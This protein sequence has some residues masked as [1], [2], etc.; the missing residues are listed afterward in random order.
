[1][2]NIKW[3]I[4]L[5]C[6]F[7]ILACKQESASS[8]ETTEAVS[9]TTADAAPRSLANRPI[10]PVIGLVKPI[11]LTG[12]QTELMLEDYFM[13]VSTIE[14]F[15]ASQGLE[16]KRSADGKSLTI[17]VI[18][19]PAFYSVLS[20][21]TQ[22][23]NFDFLLQQSEKRKVTLRLRDKGYKKVQIKGEMN[24]WNPASAEMTLNRGIWEH[25]FEVHPGDYQ[26]LFV[27]DG[28][29][30][31]DPKNPDTAPNGSGGI[32]SLLS[33]PKP[34]TAELPRIYGVRSSANSIT[35]G[36]DRVGRL[37]VFWENQLLAT[38]KKGNEYT[39]LLPEEAQSRSRSFVRAF[40]Q[41]ERGVSN[42]MLLPIEKGALVSD[43]AQLNRTDKEA[44]IMYF[45]LVDRFNNG[46][47][48]NDQPVKDDRVLPQ[49]N[50][51]GGDI[52]GIT[53]KIK[54]GYFQSLNI[55]AIWLSP[56]TQN[57]EGAFQEYPEPRRW[58]TGYHGYWPVSS[59]KVDHRFGTSG[60]L[61]E[62]VEVA[63]Q[64]DINILLD[65]VCNHV[66]Q[67]HPIFQEHPE[68]ATQLDLP[69][70]RRNLRLWDE[71]RLTTWFDT[72]LPSL[73]LSDPEAIEVQS[74]SAMFWLQ[75]YGLDGFRHD[76]TKHVPIE[77]WR[78]LTRKLKE[79]VM[80]PQGRSIYQ[81]GETYG[82][83]ELIA[84]YIS[85][86]LLDSQ[87]DFNLYFDARGIIAQSGTDFSRLANSLQETF[88]Y[89]GHH[90]SM[91]YISG[92]HDIP[93]FI[94]LAG[95][96]LKFDENDREAGFNRS[97]GV[98]DP[99][100][101]KRLQMMHA[102][103]MSIPGVPVI[104]YGD[105]IGIPGAGD[106][107]NRRMMRFSGWSENEANTKEVVAQLTR[108]RKER[109]SLTY[110]ETEVLLAEKDLLVLLRSYF[111][112]LTIIVFNKSEQ[113][114]SLRFTLPDRFSDIALSTSFGHTVKQ[115]GRQ[116]SVDLPEVGF[117]MLISK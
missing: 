86:G 23:G 106:P 19:D 1:M 94:S 115:E 28:E 93:R 55:N 54:D 42:D 11:Q 21:Q 15:E 68:W 88:T 109:L 112:E 72:F 74:D 60:E 20:C 83:R 98:G 102:F 101:Y 9:E 8:T 10:P 111:D 76:A 79:E 17:Q 75:E 61:R 40:A 31:R 65:F 51:Q 50:Y 22:K 117:D 84:S 73:N 82:S 69:D 14:S 110:G 91:G 33:L 47:K 26:Y 48:T 12:I 6:L 85:A 37:F 81:I 38:E 34:K 41:N 100:G 78:R 32:N 52:A 43:A 39:F 66:H 27:V 70:G 18:G 7:S 114:R 62:L 24:A 3:V 29:D 67:Q 4:P 87:F 113:A 30:M 103:N 90:S 96:A 107:D 99:I 108:L 58:Y 35:L 13:D 36:G 80:G 95:G 71:Q 105:E 92:N 44:Q 63:H 16:L 104:F 46:N 64:N 116:I 2:K 5:V 77:F 53:Q 97:V 25:S 45:T 57:P 59:S 49:A 89:F 56:I